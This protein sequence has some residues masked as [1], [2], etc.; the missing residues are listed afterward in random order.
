MRALRPPIVAL[1]CRFLLSRP[2]T[3]HITHMKLFQ[4][5]LELYHNARFLFLTLL[6]QFCHG[7][8]EGL[9]QIAIQGLL[10]QGGINVHQGL[11]HPG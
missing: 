4:C 1:A 11:T 3:P 2:H 6:W 5:S 8:L 9:A 7:E 10:V